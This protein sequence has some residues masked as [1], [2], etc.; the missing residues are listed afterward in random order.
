MSKNFKYLM[1]IINIVLLL[2]GSK[3]FAITNATTEKNNVFKITSKFIM[4]GKLVSSPIIIAKANQKALIVLTNNNIESQALKMGLIVKNATQFK[5]NDA[6]KINYDIQFQ[7]GKEKIYSKPQ[8][9]VNLNKEKKINIPSN[10]NHSYAIE[11]L[12]ERVNS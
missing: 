1:M 9:I 2:I 6:V 12:A 7:D 11:V 10:S 8:V 3:V 4:D 5:K